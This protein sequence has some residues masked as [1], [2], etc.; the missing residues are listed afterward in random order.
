MSKPDWKDAPDDAEFARFWMGKWHFFKHHRQSWRWF[1]WNGVQ[2]ETTP[3][4]HSVRL[5]LTPRIIDTL[6]RRP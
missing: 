1:S 5:S 4:S 2:W 6:E 3:M